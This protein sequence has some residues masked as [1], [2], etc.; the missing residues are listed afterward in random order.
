MWLAV[1][2]GP[3]HVLVTA[4]RQLTWLVLIAL[5][6]STLS[7]TLR[8]RPSAEPLAPGEIDLQT[9]SS[10]GAADILWVDA[11]SKAKFESRHI[12]GAL[13]LNQAEWESL[14]SDFYDQWQPGRQVVVYGEVDQTM[15][16][17]WRVG[18]VTSPRL[19]MSGC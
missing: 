16:R 19:R 5:L 18:C 3:R 9:L 6:L 8:K 1:H 11:R 12:P 17:R 7:W 14:A 10:M 15:A 13:L 4:A 2:F